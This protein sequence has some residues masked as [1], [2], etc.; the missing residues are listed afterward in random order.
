MKLCIVIP[1]YNHGDKIRAVVN[2][3]MFLRLP[4]IIV[5]DCSNDHHRK[6]IQA[7][8]QEV[9]DVS[10][11]THM[12]NQG[13]GG[14]VMTGMKKAHELGYSHM[15]QVDA[16]GQHDINNCEKLIILAKRYPSQVISGRPVYD[17][18]IPLGRRLGRHI[19]HFWVWVETL[20]FSIKDTMCGFR[21]YP[22][23]PCIELMATQTL[24]T[25]MDFDIEVMVRLYWRGVTTRFLLTK[26]IYPEDGVSHFQPVADNVRITWLHTRLFFGMLIR[27]PSLLLRKVKS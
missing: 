23:A 24:G 8:D 12:T 26:V 7:V 10:V 22:L 21:V 16:D 11:V 27:I 1:N 17:E 20:S 4:I 13:K 18:S 25:R 2:S 5:D 9:E 19:T 15:L 3:L 6:L 14:A